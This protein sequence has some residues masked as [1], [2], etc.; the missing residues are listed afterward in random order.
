[1]NIFT[2]DVN[3]VIYLTLTRLFQMW[4]PVVLPGFQISSC[5][6]VK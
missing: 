2:E 5:L 6:K 1:M 3:L 4:M